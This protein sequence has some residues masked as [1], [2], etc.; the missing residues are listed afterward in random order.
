M[1]NVK[2]HW[3]TTFVEST[4]KQSTGTRLQLISRA[5]QRKPA[6]H[7]RELALLGCFSR[8]N[9]VRSRAECKVVW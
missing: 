7:V 3:I 8:P 2:M 6:H 4:T 9:H 1:G 5:H